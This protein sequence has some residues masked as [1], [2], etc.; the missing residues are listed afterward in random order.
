MDGA[1]V[2]CEEVAQVS[3]AH[4]AQTSALASR[5]PVSAMD[6]AR[7]S[8]QGIEIAPEDLDD[9]DDEW[10]C[11][12]ECESIA[13]YLRQ[14]SGICQVVDSPNPRGNVFTLEVVEVRPLPAPRPRPRP[15]PGSRGP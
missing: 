15:S 14:S 8:P 4:R 3:S 10:N 13:T 2:H 1:H 12:P 5:P 6:S 9:D 11:S 7:R